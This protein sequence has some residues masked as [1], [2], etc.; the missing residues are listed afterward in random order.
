[1]TLMTGSV[2]Q[3]HKCE[4]I[5][6]FLLKNMFHVYIQILQYTYFLT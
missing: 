3:G 2:V 4:A 6:N 1:M 5:H